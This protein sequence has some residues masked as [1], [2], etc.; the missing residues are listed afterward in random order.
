MPYL[1]YLNL[2]LPLK[3]NFKKSD[4]L[5]LFIFVLVFLSSFIEIEAQVTRNGPLREYQTQSEK[6]KEES[7]NG[8][9]ATKRA[10]IN[11]FVDTYLKGEKKF[12]KGTVPIVIHLMTKKK[13]SIDDVVRQ[14][15]SLSL[16]FN[17]TKEKQLFKHVADKRKKFDT[18]VVDIGLNFCLARSN[19][20]GEKIDALTIYPQYT[21]NKL[22]IQAIKSKSKGGVSPI[23]PE[24]ILNVWVVDL[25]EDQAGFA[26]MPGGNSA[27]DGIVINASYFGIDDNKEN[28]Y[29][30]GK[31]LT[32][33]VGS[34]LGLYELWNESEPCSDDGIKDT[35]IHNGPNYFNTQY[36]H[37]SLCSGYPVELT[38]NYMDNTDDSELTMFTKGQGER[39]LA[40]LSDEGARSLLLDNNVKC[41][42][43]LNNNVVLERNFQDLEVSVY[44]NPSY[45]FFNLEISNSTDES[46]VEIDIFNSSGL[47]VF[48]KTEPILKNVKNIF[49][50]DCKN[51]TSG[52]FNVIVKTKEKV[53]S[54]K[55]ILIK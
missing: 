54:E 41:D 40:I 36:K 39:V 53:I 28:P 55:L 24:Q 37:I 12:K 18:L 14:I 33:L 4:T 9:I 31:T 2:S 42:N 23:D 15:D 30:G 47:L 52:I 19:S 6:I 27:E 20:K 51:F 7:K 11:Q 8:S 1:N 21:V 45:E 49:T 44:P 25:E 38:M 13:I 26:Q 32:H 46:N 48:K 43:N 22:D 16:D 3:Y 34:Y 35:P 17:R 5:R 50:I 29:G 10:S